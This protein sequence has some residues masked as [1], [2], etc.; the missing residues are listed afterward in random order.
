[1]LVLTSRKCQSLSLVGSFFHRELYGVTYKGDVA[2]F[3]QSYAMTIRS[4]FLTFL[5]CLFSFLV[6]L[7]TSSCHLLFDVILEIPHFTGTSTHG[8]TLL[9]NWKCFRRERPYRNEKCG[10]PLGTL[11][12]YPYIFQELQSLTPYGAQIGGEFFCKKIVVVC[13]VKKP[14]GGVAM[15]AADYSAPQ[16]D[17]NSRGWALLQT[18]TE[19]IS[20]KEK[21]DPKYM[22][23]SSMVGFLVR[24]DL[25]KHC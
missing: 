8:G 3:P 14:W 15:E 1:M 17:I 23:W 7:T 16:S 9:W 2:L 10:K 20:P 4:L 24:S 25:L 6:P 12:H 22:A 21:S 19:H 13:R 11:L 5:D 18:F